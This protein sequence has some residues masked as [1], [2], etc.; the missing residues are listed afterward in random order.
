M[1]ILTI[2]V[3]FSLGFKDGITYATFIITIAG[4]ICWYIYIMKKEYKFYKLNVAVFFTKF[5]ADLF[6]FPPY[7]GKFNIVVDIMII[8]LSTIDMMFIITWI[9]YK[10]K[11]KTHN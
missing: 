11:Q 10:I 6:C 4:V 7:F 5:I 8:I 9:T 3:F 2:I 1:I